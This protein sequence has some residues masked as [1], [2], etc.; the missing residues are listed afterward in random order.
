MSEQTRTRM[1]HIFHVLR[2]NKI[3]QGLTPDKLRN[4]LEGLGPTF[5]KFGQILSMRPD[6]IPPEYC[7]ELTKLRSDVNPMPFSLVKELIEAECHQGL[8][9]VFSKID[10]VPLGSASIGQVH[11][12][13]LKT[14]QSV[15]I[16]IQRPKVKET[17]KQD[18]SLCKKAM[19][20][21]KVMRPAENAVDFMIVLD[22]MWDAAQK[23]FDFLQE[24]D[25]LK[26]YA[27]LNQDIKY[28]SCPGVI[29]EW[30]TTRMLMMEYIDGIPIDAV[31]LLKIL[32][33]D[34]DEIGEKLA[35]NY[36]KQVLEDG[37][38]QAD[39]HPGNISIRDGQIIWMDMGM[40]ARL[41]ERDKQIFS[42]AVEAITFGDIYELKEAVLALGVRHEK[43][44]HNELYND[45]DYI[46]A[47]YAHAKF[48]GLSLSE[49]IKD[50][51][52]VLNRHHI[53]IGRGMSMLIRGVI[54]IEG[55]LAQISPDIDFMHIFSNHMKKKEIHDIDVKEEIKK[56]GVDALHFLK[57]TVNLP[58]N[59]IDL[60]KMTVKGQTK[61]NIELSESAEFFTH[62]DQMINKLVI[63]LIDVALLIGSSLI[64]TTNMKGQFFGI[65]ALGAFGYLLAIILGAWLLWGIVKKKK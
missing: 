7:Q 50:I 51:Q 32:G 16:K 58:V 6:L 60:I 11:K 5:I 24:A 37:F 39:P 33:Y 63:A 8:D 15:V 36:V 21:L 42:N 31:D 28:V 10:P 65:P 45:I 34:M 25:N 19:V 27:K 43:I 9:Q 26:K 61:I 62:L 30:S 35:E 54:T 55:V 56:N 41:S 46:V 12:A 14:G 38:F 57:K 59:I 29:D 40:M 20:A 53:T 22:E 1:R 13:T 44:D 2:E 47:K 64:C 3:V 52:E 23:E 4:I 48:Q 18:I 49:I 17:M